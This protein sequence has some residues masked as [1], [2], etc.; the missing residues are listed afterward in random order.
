MDWLCTW[1]WPYRKSLMFRSARGSLGGGGFLGLWVIPEDIY[2]RKNTHTY[3]IREECSGLCRVCKAILHPSLCSFCRL[4]NAHLRNRYC[5]W[6]FML[7][8]STDVC[9]T[10]VVSVC[11][12]CSKGKSFYRMTNFWQAGIHPMD[13]SMCTPTITPIWGS[14]PKRYSFP[15][16]KLRCSELL[17]YDDV[18]VHKA[19][20]FQGQIGE[21]LNRVPFQWP[22]GSWTRQPVFWAERSG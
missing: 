4:L 18:P 6:C 15:S 10:A 3:R 16:L 19:S 11:V 12:S 13:K 7:L 1:W 21:V 8:F 5:K 14:S 20:S 9:F 17:Q 2:R 22:L